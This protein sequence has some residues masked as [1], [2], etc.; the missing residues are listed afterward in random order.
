MTMLMHYTGWI[1][2]FETV[3]IPE[4]DVFFSRFLEATNK[5]EVLKRL[6]KRVA[7]VDWNLQRDEWD[8]E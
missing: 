2:A 8:A 1:K 6:K 3:V 4:N 7:R 5:D